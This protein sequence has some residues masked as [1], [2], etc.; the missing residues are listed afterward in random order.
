MKY[1]T[2]FGVKN[3]RMQFPIYL[4]DAT[5][6][7]VRSIDAGDLK[8][9]GVRGIV[10]NTYHL[11]SQP[12]TEVLESAGGIKP[13]MGWD[14]WVVSDSGGFQL[15]SLIYRNKSFGHVT[16]EG[17]VF[18]RG[19]SGEKKKYRFTPEKSIQVQFSIGADILICLDDCPAI[20]ARKEENKISVERTVEW[21]K[22]CKEEYLRQIEKNKVST[23][24]RPLLF[25]VI[26]GGDDKKS[27]EKCAKELIKIGFDGFCFG[28][29]PLDKQGNLKSEILSFTAALMPDNLPK[30][31]LGVGNPQAIVES[32]KMGYSIFDCVLPTRDARH[33]RLY[34]FSRDPEEI[35]MLSGQET[36]NYLYISQEKYARDARPVSQFCDCYACKNYSRAYLHHLF[37]IGDPLAWRLSTI[38]NLRTY[39]KLIE[40][41]RKY[42]C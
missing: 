13:Y 19:S 20:N 32:F 35:N 39:T 31:A 27:R 5:R 42:V 40:A 3:K 14:G 2:Q 37:K 12:G 24:N 8:K 26:Q 1:L 11:M 16:T 9:A 23:S 4:P 38:H 17:V 6:G 41:L 34:V 28:G 30:F 7:V 29:W 15:L 25:A 18:H 22:R 10:V 36:C 21:A 33:K